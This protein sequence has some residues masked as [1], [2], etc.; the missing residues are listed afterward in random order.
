MPAPPP[1]Q[2][3]K[4][5]INALDRPGT[6]GRAAGQM[7][8]FIDTER[9]PNAPALGH[10]ADAEID[11]LVRDAEAELMLSLNPRWTLEAIPDDR[12]A[13]LAMVQ[14]FTDACLQA[15]TAIGMDAEFLD[16]NRRG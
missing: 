12:F 7:Q 3:W 15:G 5:L 9:G 14:R 10:I 4:G 8:M 2:G 16:K 6:A 13:L 11:D 1:S